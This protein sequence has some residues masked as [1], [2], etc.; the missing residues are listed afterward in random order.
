[1]VLA[2]TY[3]H[4]CPV[5]VKKQLWTNFNP[6]IIKAG[7]DTGLQE[8]GLVLGHRYLEMCEDDDIWQLTAVMVVQF[9]LNSGR[10]VI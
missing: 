9:L 5:F 2:G 4:S 10:F 8:V 7:V 6:L 3:L 1:M